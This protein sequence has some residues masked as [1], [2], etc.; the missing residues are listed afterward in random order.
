MPLLATTLT[1][2]W[3]Q[4]FI[5]C[6]C[7]LGLVS[8]IQ[9]ISA[10]QLRQRRLLRPLPL[11]LIS[12][13]LFIIASSNASFT[14]THILML[15][16]LYSLLRLP[17]AKAEVTAIRLHRASVGLLALLWLVN[18]FSANWLDTPVV[19]IISVHAIVLSWHQLSQPRKGNIRL[20]MRLSSV[21]LAAT[22]GLQL[23]LSLLLFPPLLTFFVLL[24][25]LVAHANALYRTTQH[26][27]LTDQQL[28][29]YRQS[30]VQQKHAVEAMEFEFQSRNFELE[31]T[32]RE[33][34]ETNRKLEQ[35]TTTDALSGA[36]NR[37]FFDQK[38]LAELR[39][40]RREQTCLSL[41]MLDIDHFKRVNDTYGHLS[42]DD[43]IK[44]VAQ[45]AHS[46][47]KRPSDTLCRY[48][49]E[50]FAIILPNTPASGAVAVAEAVLESIRSQPCA[51][52]SGPL[53]IT[54]SAGVTSMRCDINTQP[55][56]IIQIADNALYQ[57]KQ[58]G[59]DNVQWLSPP[60]MPANC[61]NME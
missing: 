14:L 6:G 24:D 52:V 9:L 40:S 31:V 28:M 57:A 19:I 44:L 17:L 45:R 15:W 4:I 11:L 47:L 32:L 29:Q 36:K 39:R 5:I 42:G 23:G 8:L 43:C 18:L 26:Q 46:S 54:A 25:T 7:L 49:G 38:L 13:P 55:Q 56:Q 59:R 22:L 30:L 34:E 10:I 33:L 3:Q 16:L 60:D 50:E 12:A 27:A 37:K 53:S 35:Q 51:T 21:L 61:T 58:A 41:I 2:F 48:G 1:P 20:I